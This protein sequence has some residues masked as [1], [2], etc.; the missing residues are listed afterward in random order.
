MVK[1]SVALVV[2]TCNQPEYL[3]R[4]LSAVSAQS[5]LP[6]EVVL[7]DDGSG[8]ETLHVFEQWAVAQAFSVHHAW[9]EKNG[10]RR[11]RILNAA[12][13]LAR[14]EYIIFLDGDTIP[15][16]DFTADHRTLAKRNFF[17]QGHRV[18]VSQKASHFFGAGDFSSDR[19]RAFF[20]G[21]L[22]GFKHIF[23]WLLP[24]KR[25][26]PNL[27]GVRGCNLSVWRSDLV[28][29]NGYNEDYF[30]WG[31]EDLDLALRLMNCGIRRLDVRGRALCYHL[32]HPLLDRSNLAANQRIL[33]E[34]ASHQRVT[35]EH[36]LNQHLS[37]SEADAWTGP[38]VEPAPV[39]A[40]ET[41]RAWTVR[42]RRRVDAL[43]FR[44]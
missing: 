13:A 22:K 33:A 9:H 24:F 34:T 25:I 21:Q 3:A 41:R 2:N 31:C 23:R 42:I 39:P 12:I 30:G 28:K 43:K 29:I 20:S 38:R 35:C 5:S 17:I 32:W 6:D 18:L 1:A 27:H 14:S 40:A 26:V 16:R 7:A 44:A 37:N 11:S 36:G 8:E 19:R 10:F 4:V 15:H